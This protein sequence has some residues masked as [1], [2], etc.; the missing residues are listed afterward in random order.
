MMY[1]VLSTIER[2]RSQAHAPAR[3]GAGG[4]GCRPALAP[5]LA[6]GAATH[7]R[8][9]D[10]LILDSASTNPFLS[11]GVF[12]DVGFADSVRAEARVSGVNVR[13]RVH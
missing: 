1:A 10:S 2:D 8:I 5:N 9:H 4:M 6:R 11:P 12:S 13:G 7:R 3:A